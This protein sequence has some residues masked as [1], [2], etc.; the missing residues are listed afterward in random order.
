MSAAHNPERADERIAA[1]SLLAAVTFANVP[2][3]C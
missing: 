1:G 3:V 2:S